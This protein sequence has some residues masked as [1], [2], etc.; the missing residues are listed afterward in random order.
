MVS[1]V[2]VKESP[3]S[4]SACRPHWQDI[5]T[6]RPVRGSVEAPETQLHLFLLMSLTPHAGLGPGPRQICR[7]GQRPL[8]LTAG[9]GQEAV[10][11]CDHKVAARPCKPGSGRCLL[12]ERERLCS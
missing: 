6:R 9:R 7:A 5:G 4:K 3:V 12:Q 2:K 11:L 10:L 1:L 8:P